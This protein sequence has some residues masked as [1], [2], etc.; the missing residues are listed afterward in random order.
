VEKLFYSFI[1]PAHSSFMLQ[2]SIAIVFTAVRQSI[3]FK[4]HSNFVKIKILQLDHDNET[5]NLICEIY[6]KLAS[7]FP[8][9]GEGLAA[10]CR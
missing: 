10:V 9:A 7:S 6:H 4:N 3:R 8:R 1:K 5:S 2:C